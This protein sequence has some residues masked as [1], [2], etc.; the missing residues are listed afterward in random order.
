MIDLW[1]LLFEEVS[2]G[3]EWTYHRLNEVAHAQLVEQ[4]GRLAQVVGDYFERDVIALLGLREELS[5][6]GRQLNQ[7]PAFPRVDARVALV[8]LAVF[9]GGEVADAEMLEDFLESRG[10][11]EG[12]QDGLVGELGSVR[13]G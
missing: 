8:Q 5:G 6:A 9:L 10:L 13:S 11:G 2:G 12:Q 4:L 7:G 1:L 3:Q